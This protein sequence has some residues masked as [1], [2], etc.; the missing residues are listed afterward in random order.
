[1]YDSEPQVFV[2]A[3]KDHTRFVFD[4]SRSDPY[5]T[6]LNNKISQLDTRLEKLSDLRLGEYPL[7]KMIMQL[8]SNPD[9]KELK[10]I[11]EAL[12]RIADILPKYHQLVERKQFIEFARSNPDVTALAFAD[13]S[14][15]FQSFL[16]ELD[17]PDEDA[18]KQ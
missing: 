15:E 7:I 1:M 9:P 17:V 3:S 6:D 8:S 14:D 11:A 18:T 12:N 5:L 2:P 16:R 10:D 13:W 4:V